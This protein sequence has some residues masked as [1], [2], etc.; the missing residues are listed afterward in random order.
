MITF[1]VTVENHGSIHLVRPATDDV[2]EWLEASTDGLW[3][4]GGLAVEP[5][6]TVDLLLGLRDAGFSV[7]LE[8]RTTD[9]SRV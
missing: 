8:A 7:P 9:A 2:R 5:R 3:F 4:A 1:D 6:Y